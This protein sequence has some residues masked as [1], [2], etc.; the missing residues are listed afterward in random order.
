MVFKSLNLGT[1]AFPAAQLSELLSPNH[2]Q[3]GMYVYMYRASVTYK[4]KVQYWQIHYASEQ[5]IIKQSE[6]KDIYD[7][8]A[9]YFP[10]FKNT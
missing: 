8:K 2:T 10:F 1:A 7:R 6:R 3:T 4:K 5:Q 9:N